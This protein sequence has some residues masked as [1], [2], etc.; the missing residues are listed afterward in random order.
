MTGRNRRAK[1]PSLT[2]LQQAIADAI[3]IAAVQL[4]LADTT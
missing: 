2:P 1:R 4:G 3:D